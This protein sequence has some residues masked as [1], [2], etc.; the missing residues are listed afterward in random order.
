MPRLEDISYSREDCV[1]AFRDYYTFLTKMY[2]KDSILLEPPEGGWPLITTENLQELGKSEEVVSLLRHLPY[3]QRQYTGDDS[4]AAP[5]CYFADWQFNSRALIEGGMSADEIKVCSE[6]LYEHIPPQVIGLTFGGRINPVFLLD[7]ALGIVHWPECPGEIRYKPFRE[8]VEDDPYD[9]APENEAE[10]RG[11]APAWTIADFLEI[12]KNEFRELQFVPIGW[13]RV[14]EVYA[15]PFQGTEKML[16][17][18]Q[19]IYREHGWPELDRYR[20]LE[21]LQAVQTALEE[22]YPDDADFIEDGCWEKEKD[23]GDL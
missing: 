13:R 20:K 2:L 12:L 9:Y 7:T 19:G 11:D 14:R 6:S 22:Y 16:S 3:I 5:N 4:H 17:M 18:L 8:L 21:C 10:W 1:A 23:K 15:R